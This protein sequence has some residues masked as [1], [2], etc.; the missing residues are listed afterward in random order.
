MDTEA[1][2]GGDSHH[3]M[4]VGDDGQV[5]QAGAERRPQVDGVEGSDVRDDRLG[6]LEHRVV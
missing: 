4:V 5:V 3:G 2:L 1:D 6:L